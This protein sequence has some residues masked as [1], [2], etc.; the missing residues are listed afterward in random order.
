M[1]GVLEAAPMSRRQLEDLG[2]A[3]RK[4]VGADQDPWFPVAHVI[5]K[6]L[7]ALFGEDFAFEIWSRREMGEDQHAFASVDEKLLVLREDV[8][9]GLIA[10]RGRD[11]MTAVHELAHLIL[12]PSP[13]L[14]RRMTSAPITAFRDPEWQAKCLAGAIMM[15]AAMM[16]DAKSLREVTAE[17]GVSVAAAAYRANRQLG[18]S[19]R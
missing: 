15:P 19:L 10:H 8:Y 9:E 16:K 2:W 12:H 14:S 18:M 5:E 7:P 3:M 17:F 4:L 1:S 13:R 11:R 6:S